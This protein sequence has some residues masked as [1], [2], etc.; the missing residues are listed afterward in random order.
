M[1]E[2]PGNDGMQLVQY[3]FRRVIHQDDFFGLNAGYDQ[4]CEVYFTYIKF[5]FNELI[6]IEKRIN[7]RNVQNEWHWLRNS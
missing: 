1:K 5:L 4:H 2:I 6:Q 7:E 3:Y